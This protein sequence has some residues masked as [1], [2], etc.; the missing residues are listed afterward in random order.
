MKKRFTLLL[1]ALVLSYNVVG[2]NSI[3]DSQN[4][5]NMTSG[6]PENLLEGRVSGLWVSRTDGNPSSSIFSAIRGISTLHGGSGP[7]WVVDGVILSDAEAQRVNTFFRSEYA[8]Y[9]QTSQLNG[10][11]FLNLYDVESI[12]V[13]KDVSATAIY[14][15]KGANGV[16]LIT[17][18][19]PHDKELDLRWDSNLGLEVSDMG[20]TPSFSHNHNVSAHIL[21]NRAGYSLSAYFRDKNHPVPGADEKMGGL[22]LK[23]HTHTNKLIWFG[24]NTNLSLGKQSSMLASSDMGASTMGTALRK[25]TL[26]SELNSIEG[27]ATD[28]DDINDQLRVTFD[29]YLRVNFLPVLYWETRVGADV[30]NNTRNHWFG[31][32]TQLG[33]MKN[34]AAAYTV[35]SVQRY[36]I[37]SYLAYDM[38]FKYDHRLRAE[39]GV[40][41]EN[42]KNRFEINAAD[43]FLTDALRGDGMGFRESVPHPFWLSYSLNEFAAYGTLSYSWRDVI[44]VST[45]FRA[46]N[47]ARYDDGEYSLYP[48]GTASIDFHKLFF[49]DATA[50]SALTLE[51]SYGIAGMKR[52]VPYMALDR[53]VSQSALDEAFEANSII[54]DPED[55][56]NNV[57]SFFEAFARTTVSEYHV[58]L[59]TAF[60]SDRIRVAARW[61][62]RRSN[63]RFN[64][65]CFG[66]AV[67]DKSHVWMTCPRWD[68]YEETLNFINSGVEVDIAA[69]LFRN[70]DINWSIQANASYNNWSGAAD[71]E[72]NPLP[73]VLTGVGTQF[74]YKGFTAEVW[75]NGAFGHKICNLNRMYSEGLSDPTECIENAG[76]FSLSNIALSYRFDIDRVK[77]IKSV[78][79]SVAA[80]NIVTISEY[81]G[82]NPNV[83]SYAFQG[84]RSL[85]YDYGSLPTAAALMFG[86][87]VIF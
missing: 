46:D 75:G 37:K 55:K 28:Y 72:F 54:V 3:A 59:N 86:V 14:G 34:R 68:V 33:S 84:N 67:S 20:L 4:L 61:Y 13:L 5:T 2:Q 76:Y 36:N 25:L 63:D 29:T 24:F 10:L 50:I 45:V 51:G 77:F 80:S 85:G 43:H 32:Q 31:L 12:E 70:M 83:N 60:L 73:T 87:S 41:F 49:K 47:C 81:S 52:Y 42:D 69:E 66:N 65:Y 16:I 30:G 6:T 17:T 1:F 35:S 27:W 39:V 9:Q 15:S 44:N 40:A 22:R 64:L 21:S 26:P 56:T 58:G 38:R 62:D 74:T 48:S 57:T 53:F 71:L 11:S 82:L 78:K 7:L 18:K 8:P 23:F 79:A 19:S